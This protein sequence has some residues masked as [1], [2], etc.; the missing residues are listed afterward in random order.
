MCRYGFHKYKSHYACFTCR[1]VF[2]VRP[3]DEWASES[4]RNGEAAHEVLCPDCRAAM[5]DMGLDFKAPPKRNVKQ[6]KKVELLRNAGVG[7]SSCGCSGPGYRPKTLSEVPAF[8]AL[9][10]AE[11]SRSE[12][13]VRRREASKRKRKVATG[14]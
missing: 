1:K 10:E 9:R 13:I 2:R 14:R 5:T 8:L 6:W 11:R 12:K 7:Y 4:V 3:F